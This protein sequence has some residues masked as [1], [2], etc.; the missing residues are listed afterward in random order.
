MYISIGMCVPILEC[1]IIFIIIG[2]SDTNI[3]GDYFITQHSLT[4]VKVFYFLLENVVKTYSYL[5]YYSD[6]IFI[7]SV[8]LES[9]IKFGSL[10]SSSHLKHQTCIGIFFLY[11]LKLKFFFKIIDILILYLA[12]SFFYQNH[13][14]LYEYIYTL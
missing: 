12:K 2:C 3:Q 8:L 1:S 13:L 10:N 11:I 5:E 4:I 6:M 9:S 14:S 7:H